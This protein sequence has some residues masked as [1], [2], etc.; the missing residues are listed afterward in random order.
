[1]VLQPRQIRGTPGAN[2]AVAGLQ[3]R[4]AERTA[5]RHDGIVDLQPGLARRIAAATEGILPTHDVN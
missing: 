1:G 2:R 5:L 3:M 4:A